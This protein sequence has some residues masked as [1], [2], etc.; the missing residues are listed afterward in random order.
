MMLARICSNGVFTWAAL[1]LVVACAGAKKQPEAPTLTQVDTA[2]LGQMVQ[3]VQTAEAPDA[4]D[5]A[6]ALLEQAA[7]KDPALWEARYNAG[8][9]LAE[10]DKLADAEKYLT[11]AAELAPNAEDVALALGEVRRRRG[12][13][14]L[15]ADGLASFVASYPDA[16]ASRIALVGAL[17]ESDRIDEAMTQAEEV[18]K[19]RPNDPDALAALAL[20]HLD[21][22]EADT[23]ELL[24]NESLKSEHKTALVERTAGL[25][26]LERG[27]DAIAFQ[28]FARASELDPNDTTA[29]MNMGVVLLQAGVY[30]RAE[31]E[32]RGVL[33]VEPKNDEATLGLAASLRGQGKRESPGPY[34]EAE[35]LLQSLLDRRPDQI[36]ALFNLAVLYSDFLEKPDKARPLYQRFL[37]DAPAKHPSRP[38]AEKF[39]K[40]SAQ[41]AAPAPAPA[42]TPTGPATTPA[43]LTTTDAP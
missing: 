38:I 43:G 34:L 39:L 37:D 21:R 30:P 18:L 25:I 1:S 5:R 7:T 4:R 27:D 2:A 10:R 9:L 32:F 13:A 16:V 8:V 15:A 40:D 28:H 19:R 12:E 36:A 3:G 26:A 20:A 6:I 11:R 41:P 14:S 33:D 42:K 22:G 24:S 31:K 17:R 29:R 35:K 23:A